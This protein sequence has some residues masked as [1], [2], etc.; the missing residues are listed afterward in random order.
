MIGID[1]SPNSDQTSRSPD[2]RQLFA[3]AADDVRRSENR[4]RIV[5]VLLV[6]VLEADRQ[7]HR[8]RREIHDLLRRDAVDDPRVCLGNARFADELGRIQRCHA[9]RVW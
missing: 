2:H 1:S 8:A 7:A 9:G 5:V 6:L 3:G 4:R